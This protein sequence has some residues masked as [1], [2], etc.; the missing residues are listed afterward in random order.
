MKKK[1]LFYQ[2]F[3]IFVCLFFLCPVICSGQDI[4]PITSNTFGEL[5][6]KVV[7][8]IFWIAAIIGPLFIILGGF[9][10]LFAGM[11][12]SKIVLGKKI[13]LY[14]SVVF[15]IILIIKIMTYYFSSDLTLQ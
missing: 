13:I 9:M 14:T 10:M 2:T 1:I 5:L 3:F 11:D 6:D 15:G 4:N 7:G 8:V 12:P